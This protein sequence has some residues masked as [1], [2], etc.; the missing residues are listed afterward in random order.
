MNAESTHLVYRIVT[1]RIGRKQWRSE[2]ESEVARV[3]KREGADRETVERLLGEVR[4]MYAEAGAGFSGR[5][6]G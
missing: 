2:T 6:Q 1:D 5:F 3:A 4:R